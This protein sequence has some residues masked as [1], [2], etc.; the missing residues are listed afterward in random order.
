MQIYTALY[1][2]SVSN[3]AA[4]QPLVAVAE[5]IL[6]VSGNS[7]LV[8]PKWPYLLGVAGLGVTLTRV[9]LTSPK[10]RDIA[11]YELRPVNLGTK[12]ESPMR[13]DSKVN[14]PIKLDGNERLDVFVTQGSAG[15]EIEYV[16]LIFGDGP[17]KPITG[18]VRTVRA[19]GTTT[20]GAATWSTVPLTF[21]SSLPPGDY[22]IVGARMESATARA[23]RLIPTG[24]DVNNRPGGFA[25]QASDD[26]LI[27]GQRRGNWGAWMQFNTTQPPSAEVYASAADSSETIWLDLIQGK[28]G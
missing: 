15:A 5:Q 25:N 3:A 27:D 21:D 9:Q 20:L 24:G 17:Y 8:H 7:Y 19:T 11:P 1:S 22:T 6:Q 10:I 2:S 26:F 28:V 18:D 13:W 12:W 16:M 4:L 14:A 23:F